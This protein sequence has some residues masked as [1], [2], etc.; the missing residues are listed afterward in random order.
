M[1]QQQIAIL[2]SHSSVTWDKS[3]P[4]DFKLLSQNNAVIESMMIPG[5][6]Y[7]TVNP[8][9]FQNILR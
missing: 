6:T 4:P 1:I 2:A 3:D 7:G 9:L 5:T 8:P